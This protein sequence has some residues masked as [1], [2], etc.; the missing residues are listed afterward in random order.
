MKKLKKLKLN[1]K[2]DPKYIPDKPTG[3]REWVLSALLIATVIYIIVGVTFAW[4]IYINGLIS[5]STFK[6]YPF[7][8]ARVGTTIIPVSRYYRDLSAINKYIVESGTIEDYKDLKVSRQVMD[9]L[10]Q[11]ALYERIAHRYGIIVTKEE[12]DAAYQQSSQEEE[13]PVERILEQYYGFTPEDFKIWIAEYITQEKV[14]AEVPVVRS[15][16]HILIAVDQNA[17][18][19]AV[20]AA[21]TK[22][23]EVWDKLKGGADF[24]T[25]AREDSNDLTSRDNGGSLGD[26]SR[27][28]AGS[29]VIDQTFEDTAFVAPL[30]ELAGPVR[31]T[32]GFHII[33]VTGEKGKA[34]M[35]I[36]DIIKEEKER[37]GIEKYVP[38]K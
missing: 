22:A 21:R 25:L 12:V 26:I 11:A 4:Q 17:D 14:R 13:E 35:H 36:D 6:W 7:P 18:E 3:T 37:A 32:R 8:A 30:N 27:G 23:N 31:S 19:A 16:N 29:P 38:L 33:L 5:P 9:R 34:S 24:A 20:E 28:R 15:I 10:I 2:I 1:L